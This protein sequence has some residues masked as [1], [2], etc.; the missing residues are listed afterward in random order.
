MPFAALLLLALLGPVAPEWRLDDQFGRPHASADYLGKPVLLIA[1]G[2]PAAKTFD[3]WIDAVLAAY[4]GSTDALPFHV[5]GLADIGN[6][7]RI[8]HGLITLGLPRDRRR[9]VLIDPNGLVSAQYGVDSET[10]NQLV[11][12]HD[13]TV[14]LHLRGIPVDTAQARLVAER[15]RAAVTAAGAARR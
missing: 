2:S 3:R 6:A 15:L 1:G 12:G 10:S 4:G 7:P 8:T 11:L 13:G 5:L 14:L 9:P